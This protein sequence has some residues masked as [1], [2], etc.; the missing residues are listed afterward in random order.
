MLRE[1]YANVGGGG[2]SAGKAKAGTPA[3][4]PRA[5]TTRTISTAPARAPRSSRG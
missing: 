3:R 2:K 5:S 1:V 4:A